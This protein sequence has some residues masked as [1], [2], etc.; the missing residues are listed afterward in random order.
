MLEAGLGRMLA[1]RGGTGCR[2]TDNAV[3]AT[4]GFAPSSITRHLRALLDAAPV[5]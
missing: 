1:C 5:I 2:I 3:R 4:P